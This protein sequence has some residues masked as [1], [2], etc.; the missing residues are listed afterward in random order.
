MPATTPLRGY[1]YPLDTDPIDVAGD[2][3]DLADAI[4]VDMT[5]QLQVPVNVYPTKAALDAASTGWPDGAQAQAPAG[6]QWIRIA[7][8][9]RLQAAM[10][11]QQWNV[12]VFGNNFGQGINTLFG[13]FTMITANVPMYWN[14]WWNYAFSG[15]SVASDYRTRLFRTSDGAAVAI[16][17]YD[18]YAASQ[19]LTGVHMSS[20]HRVADSPPQEIGFQLEVVTAFANTNIQG[21][22]LIQAIP[23]EA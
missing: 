15:H 11:I 7:G 22:A 9:W 6:T 17:G 19:P 2:I 4:D 5:Q 8:V 23:A 12:S 10:A 14:V 13:S 21:G 3:K 20:F 16:S 1:P 18:H